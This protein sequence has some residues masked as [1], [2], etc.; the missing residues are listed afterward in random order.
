M[1]EDLPRLV[2]QDAQAEL[3]LA[4]SSRSD[5]P[6]DTADSELPF[7]AAAVPAYELRLE[8][9]ADAADGLEDYEDGQPRR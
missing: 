8:S 7:D 4:E 2:E 6:P 5:A 3:A 1:P 9:L